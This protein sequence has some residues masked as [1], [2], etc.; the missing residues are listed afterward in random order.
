M[1]LFTRIGIFVAAI[2]TLVGF[3][4]GAALLF[5]EIGKNIPAIVRTLDRR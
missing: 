1:S 5:Q 3:A 4:V 2:A